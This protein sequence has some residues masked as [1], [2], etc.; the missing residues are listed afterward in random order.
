MKRYSISLI[1]YLNSRPFLYGIENAPLKEDV[2]IFLDIPSKTAV[3]LIHRQA[4]VGLVPVGA[5]TDLPGYRIVSDYCIGA[6]GP[7]RTVVLASEAPLD[8]VE[9]IQ[10]DYQSRSS[11]LLVRILSRF[12]WKREFRW[13]KSSLGYAKRVIQGKTAAV[14]IG[15]RVFDVEK[16]YRYIIDL[17]DEWMKFTGLPFV[18]AVWVAMEELPESFREQFN[19][20]IG[21]GVKSVPEVQ[22]MVKGDYPGVDLNRYFTENISY[23]LDE[24]KRQGMARFLELATRLPEITP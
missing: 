6:A 16:R 3:K 7:V 17:S 15:D 8:E 5:L 14:V 9:A 4:D 22:E 10:L 23:I 24:S 13:E 18:F 11:V 2:E 19:T 20:A 1:S 12:F 21:L